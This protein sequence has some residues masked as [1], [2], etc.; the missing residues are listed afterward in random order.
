MSQVDE[1]HF[2][3]VPVEGYPDVQCAVPLPIYECD[4]RACRVERRIIED[5]AEWPDDR[6]CK[7]IEVY[8]QKI[9]ED[10]RALSHLRDATRLKSKRA[11]GAL[12]EAES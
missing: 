10:M 4:D 7:Q 11:G 8:E 5:M 3:A 2:H 12:D 1:F 6:L 9:A